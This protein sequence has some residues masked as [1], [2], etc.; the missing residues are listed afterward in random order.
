MKGSKYITLTSIF[1]AL[2]IVLSRILSIRV[3]IGG[4]EG[5]RIGF[6]DF[7]LMLSGILFGP[8]WGGLAG[9]SADI[10]GYIISPMGPYMPH[11][12]LTSALKGII[13]GLLFLWLF[14]ENKN[15]LY[16]FLTFLITKIIVSFLIVIFIHVLFNL[17][18]LTLIPP[19]LIALLIEVPIYTILSLTLLKRFGVEF[20]LDKLNL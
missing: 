3:S 11:F 6:G 13:P 18:Y 14:R 8:F 7:P 15:F 20:S 17:P 12:T 1:I 16:L 4:V 9:I 5:I 2:S 10:I 19:R